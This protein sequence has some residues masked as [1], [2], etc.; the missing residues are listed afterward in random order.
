MSVKVLSPERRA[1]WNENSKYIGRLKNPTRSK[2]RNRLSHVTLDVALRFLW[3]EI[4]RK[5]GLSMYRGTR[6]IVYIGNASL[7]IPVYYGSAVVKISKCG[8]WG[9]VKL[10]RET[11]PQY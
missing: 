2:L 6:R 11:T 5:E 1:W 10:K 7:L 3:N 9:S 8:K 4:L